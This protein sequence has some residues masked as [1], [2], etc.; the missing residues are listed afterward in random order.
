MSEEPITIPSPPQRN[1]Q[2]REATPELKPRSRPGRSEYGDESDAPPRRHRE[3]EDETPEE[4]ELRRKLRRENETEEERAERHKRRRERERE[5]ERDR[6]GLKDGERSRGDESATGER[7]RKRSRR[8]RSGSRDSYRSHRSHRSSVRGSDDRRV[9]DREYDDGHRL[10][11]DRRRRDYEDRD[12]R[13]Y[14]DR[15]RDPYPHSPMR[16]DRYAPSPPRR[17]RG[18]PEYSPQSGMR[19][20]RSPS[21]PPPRRD[22]ADALLDSVDSETRSV[23]VSQLAAALTSRD[24]GMFFE[25]KLGRGSV[26][27][28]RVVT[29]RV[30]RRSKGIAYVEL[31]SVELVPRAIALTGT[32]VMGLPIMITF[33]EST[34]RNNAAPN[35]VSL[36]AMLAGS[37]VIRPAIPGAGLALP[38]LQV[39]DANADAVVPYHRLYVGNL[40][41]NLTSEEI[42]QVFEPFGELEFVDMPMEP[43]TNR[44]RGYAFV[45]YKELR[46]AQMA[47]EA[48]NGFELAG[49]QS[50]LFVLVLGYDFSLCTVALTY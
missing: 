34:A 48:M 47:L 35:T 50:E 14:D 40:Y 28:A 18:S 41:Y 21:P 2:D 31:S 42:R 15:R 12:R 19:P 20:M 5:R 25:D 37:S 44:S 13:Y 29:D 33:T 49:R 11:D 1:G 4:R 9:R 36:D 27:D 46:P 45:Q 38:S 43:Q 26:R 24:L 6:D 3:R 30:T 22:E 8:E 16:G 39:R 10:M 7:E 32:I 23:F 17:R